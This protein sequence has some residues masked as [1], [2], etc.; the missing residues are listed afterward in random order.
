[1]ECSALVFCRLGGYIGGSGC[2]G[3]AELARGAWEGRAGRLR[4]LNPDS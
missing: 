4:R 2:R 1:M 3:G